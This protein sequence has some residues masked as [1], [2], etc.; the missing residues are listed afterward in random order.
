MACAAE[1]SIGAGITV[2]VSLWVEEQNRGV[3]TPA[4]YVGGGLAAVMGSLP[5]LIEPAHHPHH[6]QFFHS[7]TF[8]AG[9]G[10]GMYR[11]YQWQPERD[12]DRFWR[13]FGLVAG[14][15]YLT[16]LVMDASTP[17]SIPLLGKL[18]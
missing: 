15:A 13:F 8:A 2:G 4:P 3:T 12:W 9:L 18:S 10:Y 11:L 16:H 17:R 14:G 1:H 5:D 6:R 7:L